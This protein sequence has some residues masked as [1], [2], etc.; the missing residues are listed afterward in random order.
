MS[1]EPMAAVR[2]S[3]R[4]RPIDIHAQ[5]EVVRDP[6]ALDDS[7]FVTREVTHAHK[8]LD[9]ENEEVLTAKNKKG[10][11]EIPTPAVTITPTYVT[12]YRPTFKQPTHYLRGLRRSAEYVEYDLDEDDEDWLEKYNDGQNRLPAE[13]F[14]LMLYKLEVAWAEAAENRLMEQDRPYTT[15]THAEKVEVC[16]STDALT[17][18]RATEVMRE[19]TT[20]Q[21]VLSSVYDYWL[22][23]RKRIGKPCLRRLQPP[24]QVTDT[25]PFNVFRPREKIQRPQTRRK[26]ENDIAAYEKMHGL[27]KNLEL[28]HHVLQRVVKREQRKRDIVAMECDWQALQIKYRH[29]P[30]QL[31]DA[32]ESDAAQTLR[33]RM[34]DRDPELR[35]PAGH[36]PPS[37]EGLARGIAVA[38]AATDAAAAAARKNSKKRRIR[39]GRDPRRV[40]TTPGDIPPYQPPPDPPEVEMLFAQ[41]LDPAFLVPFTMPANVEKAHCR[42]RIGRGGRLVFDRA[43]P[44]VPPMPAWPEPPRA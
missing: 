37:V 43:P 13:K 20:R 6:A 26:R 16:A 34:R 28:A 12:D 8:A 29:E 30:R 10:A 40:G 2:T 44:L 1:D 41:P 27:R 19:G 5:L 42:A 23:K 22:E 11:S 15:L 38:Q 24:P 39:D 33:Q 7:G 14:E 9:R 18:E 17:K 21:A 32:I 31:H 4:A 36:G 35:L 25:N 3:F